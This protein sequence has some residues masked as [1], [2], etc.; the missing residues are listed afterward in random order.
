MVKHREFRGHLTTR[1]AGVLSSGLAGFRN[2]TLISACTCPGSMDGMD[3]ADEEIR[4][5]TTAH[6][7][8]PLKPCYVNRNDY[9]RTTGYLTETG[10]HWNQRRP[11]MGEGET[12]RE[13][14]LVGMLPLARSYLSSTSI[15]SMPASPVFRNSWCLPRIDAAKLVF[16][17]VVQ[18]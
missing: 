17:M 12:R 18:R 9:H 10:L 3:S 1:F 6:C 8:L 14:L 11:M 13:R 5:D 2:T 4:N 7:P 16:G 15:I